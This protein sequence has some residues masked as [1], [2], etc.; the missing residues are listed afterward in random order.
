[1]YLSAHRDRFPGAFLSSPPLFFVLATPQVYFFMIGLFI[2]IRRLS[3]PF[4]HSFPPPV[5]P[6]FPLNSPFFA[7]F[8]SYSPPIFFAFRW[9]ISTPIDRQI[10]YAVPGSFRLNCSCFPFSLTRGCVLPTTFLWFTPTRFF[11][12]SAPDPGT[13]SLYTGGTVLF[14]PAGLL[15]PPRGEHVGH[16]SAPVL[17]SSLS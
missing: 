2:L 17:G 16:P 10:L 1:L 8:G 13:L 5:F 6:V 9:G 12:L 3:P 4:Q 7:V 11:S 14:M 15:F